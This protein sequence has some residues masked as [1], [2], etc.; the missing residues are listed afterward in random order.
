MMEVHFFWL[1]CVLAWS[2]WNY[3]NKWVFNKVCNFPEN[4]LAEAFG[5]IEPFNF[6]H[7]LSNTPSNFVSSW[8][9]RF[10]GWLKV[11][12]NASLMLDRPV[13]MV[14]FSKLSR[15]LMIFVLRFCGG[16]KGD[17]DWFSNGSGFWVL[18]CG[19]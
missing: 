11:N 16:A 2:I 18:S 8:L 1:F 7:V 6:V 9:P 4:L 13:T 19:S 17:C 10:L 14:M 15:A 12:C 5:Y 3:R